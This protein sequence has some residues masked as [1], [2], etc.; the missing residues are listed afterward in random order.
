MRAQAGSHRG[1]MRRALLGFLLA[2]LLVVAMSA[3]ARA[4]VP[5]HP[6]IKALI[7]GLQPEPK[8]LRPKLETPCGVAVDP[9]SGATYVSDYLRHSIMGASLPEFFP[10]NGPCALASDGTNLYVNYWHGA[11]VNV[12]ADG[13]IDAHRSTGIALDPITKNLYVDQ[14]TSVAVYEAPVEPGD[15]PAMEIGKN[16]LVDG[17]GVAVSAFAETAGDVYVGDASNNTVKVYDPT[18]S[19]EN[20]VAVIDG[21]GTAAGRFVSLQ[22]TTLAIEQGNGHLLVVD[23]T[24]PGFEHPLAAV[25]EFNAENIYRGQLEHEIIDGEP[26][27]IAIDES[28]TA[29]N[30]EVYVTSGN[31]SSI[32]I[33]PALGPP[34]SEQGALYAF[35]PSGPGQTIEVSVS[36]AGQGT[37][38]SDPAGIACPGACEA[39]LNSGAA[40]TLT[41][42]PAEGSAFAGW[43]GAAGCST[44]PTCQVVLNAPA[45]VEA[46][47]EPA[48]VPL[49][50]SA[51]LNR[52][53]ADAGQSSAAPSSS[54]PPAT[55]LVGRVSPQRDGTVLVAATV[56]GAG[57]LTA[58]GK[59]L[60]RGRTHVG[61]AGPVTMRLRLTKAGRRTLAGRKTGR[62]AL[63]AAISFRPS[64]P[65]RDSVITRTVTFN[66]ITSGGTK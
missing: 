34:V 63:H 24:Q 6:F 28:A 50:L 11:V 47:F 32:V 4:E 36:G 37:V 46:E 3:S 49:S 12:T 55:L 43:S 26:T 39:E 21:A 17:Y 29:S 65:G 48:P 5:N 15:T 45:S 56:P 42:I 51:Q 20:P 14:G 19:T 22:D 54:P 58:A 61:Q 23:N 10:D 52:A 16:S 57:E 9:A 13:V 33:P 60:R 25:D 59:D 31:G 7:S 44:E 1:T 8:P 27:G 62:L 2:P 64:G 35:G 30:G 66:R 53:S 38:K 41:A 18:V 40:V